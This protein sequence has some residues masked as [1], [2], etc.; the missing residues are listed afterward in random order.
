MTLES[1]VALRFPTSDVSMMMCLKDT[2]N[3]G[4]R[5]EAVNKRGEM[6]HVILDM[7]RCRILR[8]KQEETSGR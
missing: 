2:W 3:P 8:N 1:C 4:G 6:R 5:R 7:L